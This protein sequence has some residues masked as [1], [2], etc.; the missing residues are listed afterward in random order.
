MSSSSPP[1][2]PPPK[3]APPPPP[4][5]FQIQAAGSSHAAPGTPTR[6]RPEVHV[7][8]V[9]PATPTHRSTPSSRSTPHKARA[10]A[11]AGPAPPRSSSRSTSVDYSH[12]SAFLNINVDDSLLPTTRTQMHVHL[13]LDLD[14]DKDVPDLPD[15]EQHLLPASHSSL[16]RTARKRRRRSDADPSDRTRR[17]VRWA[18]VVV[19]GAAGIVVL[20]AIFAPETRATARHKVGQAAEAVKGWMGAGAAASAVPKGKGKESAHE[21]GGDGDEI[22]LANGEKIVYRNAFGGTFD[23]DPHSLAARAQDD[24]PPLSEEWDF[25]RLRIR[26]VNLGG[27]LTLEPFITPH[28][29]EPYI[30]AP[31]PGEDE[32]SLSLNL[33]EEGRLESTLREHYDTFITERDFIAIAGAGLNWLRLPVPYWAIQKWEDEPYLEKAAWEYVL[34]AVGWARKYGLRI[35]LDLHSVPGSQ[36]GWNHSGRLG[37][38][39]LLHSSMG[40]ANAQRALDY[41]AALAEWTSRRGVREVVPMY[42]ILNEPLLQVIGEPAL[43][44]FYRAAYET[45]R[46]ISGYGPGQG[47]FLAIHDGFK[48]TRRWFHF[49]EMPSPV[50]SAPA[51]DG[52]DRVALD[53]HRYL[54]FT[55]P[56]LRSVREQVLKPCTKWSP[57]ANKT[58]LNFGLAISGE[59]SLAVNDCGRFLNNVFQGSRL[60]GTFPN[61]TSPM[62]P[63]SAPAGTCEFWEDYERWD[64]ELRASL[65]DLA[66]AQMDTFQ[67]WFYWTW[68]TLPST[69][70]L[71]HLASN[72]LWSYSLGLTH[73]WIP[74]DPRAALDDGGFCA[75]YAA[76]IGAE[77]PTRKYP[78]ERTD[79]WKVGRAG[80]GS[81]AYT[82]RVPAD[83]AGSGAGAG[84]PYPADEFNAPSRGWGG[85]GLRVGALW[86]YAR[87]GEP[88]V[89][90][91]PPGAEG[92]TTRAAGRRWASRREGCAY[93]ATWG[94]P[95]EEEMVG[96]VPRECSVDAA[97]ERGEL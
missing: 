8:P 82:G 59:W 23:A 60:E 61:A 1:P 58:M 7:V 40:Q 10:G 57:E 41:I 64:D 22:T 16:P 90:P 11:G 55:E 44:G 80:E 28:L 74:P 49:L 79:P 67:N 92:P 51:V 12:S 46:N 69:L 75:A 93:P 31:R 66:L 4:A 9:S 47:P 2:R 77:P 83:A 14:L 24:S 48:G 25:E 35:N 37:S 52:L 86:A 3:L 72:A 27:W 78:V 26:G 97:V 30:D 13:D 17:C 15:D 89:L 20:L 45:V 85:G 18:A 42:S 65:K 63:P 81:A 87:A 94:A 54:A 43:R 84:D 70:H 68:R 34:K 95:V 76:R 56:D 96:Q 38:V 5:P 50:A 39:A 88:P 91:S 21:R 36:N 53:S 33:H 6:S 73:G 62:Y 71:P 19:A 29:F 32:Y